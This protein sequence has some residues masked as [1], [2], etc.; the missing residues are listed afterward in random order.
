MYPSIILFRYDSYSEIDSFFTTHKTKLLCEVFIHNKNTCLNHLFNVNYP[1]LVTFGKSFEEYTK[2]VYEIL[3]SRMNFR[4]LHFSSIDSL[5]TFNHSITNCYMDNIIKKKWTRPIFSIFTTCYNSYEKIKRAYSSLKEQTFKDWE[6]VILD[7]SPQDA[8]FQFLKELFLEDNR[9]RLYKRSENSGNIGNVKNEAVLLCRGEYVLELD[10]DDE[11]T[12]NCL[13]DAV[14]VFEKDKEVGFIYMNFTNIYESGDNFSYGNHYAL[15]YCGY[16]MEKYKNKWIY[17]SSSAN[18]N[19]VTLSNIVGVP[20]HPRIWRKNILLQMGNYNE[21]L[22]VSDDYELL[23]RTAVQTKMVKIHQLGYIQYMNNNENNFSLI[24]NSEIN[25]LCQHLL[26]HC[27]SS[28]DIENK[29]QEKDAFEQPHN[30]P[31]WEIENYTPHYCNAVVNLHYKKQYC[32]IGLETLYQNYK[33]INDLYK[34]KTNDFILLD[35]GNVQPICNMLDK[36]NLSN[37]KC[38][39]LPATDTELHNYFHLIYKSCSDYQFFERIQYLPLTYRIKD[40]PS[41]K[42]ITIITP[43]IRPENMHK[44]YE[45]IQWEHVAEWIIVYDGKKITENPQLFSSDKIS[46]YVYSGEGISGNP[47]RNYALDHVKHKDSFIYFL[48]D[49]NLIHPELFSIVNNL[50][51]N[52]MYTFNQ[53]RPPDVFPFTDYLKG[54]KIEVFQIDSAMFLID[55]QLCRHIRWNPYYYY[56]DGIFIM[57]CYSTHKDKWVYIDQ[58]LCYYNKL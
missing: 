22:P 43:S 48:D 46:E 10:H 56:S 24:R 2:D 20:N 54:N 1:V 41:N 29:L 19:N 28:Y 26:Y 8:H 32:I 47:Q 18:I 12:P 34:N 15:G 39:A 5:D 11:I 40:V 7:D 13:T 55:Y 27:Y 53:I 21:L 57:E 36:L 45:H 4:W 31:I 25:R 44:I 30:K 38:Y 58:I 17:V 3:P 50:Q 49:D 52:K 37:I 16:Y 9:I 51:E 14:E 23:L 35:T 33:E 6:W 42:K